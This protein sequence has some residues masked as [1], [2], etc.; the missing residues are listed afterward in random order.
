MPALDGQSSLLY[1]EDATQTAIRDAVS[2]A[3][4]QAGDAGADLIL[5]FL[6]HG[7]T[8]GN[9]P[10][11]YLM[12]SDSDEG[13]PTTLIN[14]GDLVAGVAN[15]PGI[16]SLI[17]V[18]DTCHSGGALPSIESLTAGA[19]EGATRIYVLTSA[20]PHEL[21]YDLQFS[22]ALTEILRAGLP[23]T[24]PYLHLEETKTALTLTKNLRCTYTMYDGDTSQPKPWIARNTR[25]HAPI[26]GS[27]LGEVGSQELAKSLAS[28]SDFTMTPVYG[29]ADL[30]RLREKLI[31]YRQTI[32]GASGSTAASRAIDIT[33]RLTLAQ[34]TLDLF[35]SWPGQAPLTTQRIR[36]T[37]REMGLRH[38]LPARLDGKDL[39]RHCV[40][41]LLIKSPTVQP[42]S[43]MGP[44]TRF[45]AAF[46]ARGG[47][48]ATNPRIIAWATAA[49]CEIEL[50]DAFSKIDIESKAS[51]L[52]LIISL[53]TLLT[54]EWPNT[55]EAWLLS[56]A[57]E[58]DH[59][60]Y[61]CINTQSGTEAAIT[62][63]MK[64]ARRLSKKLHLPLQRIEISASPE[65]LTRWRPEMIVEVQRLGAQ[66][67]IVLRWE[68]LL[69]PA[70]LDLGIADIARKLLETMRDDP[71]NE[72][73]VD[74]LS[75]EDLGR[76]DELNTSFQ[77][78]RFQGALALD[79]HPDNLAQVV[80][81]ALKFVPIV[82]WPCDDA[83]LPAAAKDTL[84]NRWDL[85]P[86]GFSNA[87][88]ESWLT[89]QQVESDV[90]S[91]AK[92]R[93]IW[94]DVEWL[95]FCEYF[96][97]NSTDGAIAE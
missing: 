75:T 22:L 30:I 89:T 26:E 96:D 69:S 8:Q 23:S 24:D 73:P 43:L 57:K 87:Y 31:A 62:D 63:V 70:A 41:V 68:G 77:S 21:A 49:G 91:L 17:L 12:A 5:A 67:D 53:T 51:R 11:L 86:A 1:G 88:R 47:I 54:D 60:S 15:T 94:N 25:H 90:N 14:A 76:P 4:Q 18:V 19:R 44:I 52:R 32:T 9:D 56:D 83:P 35:S 45:I 20:R 39:L 66:Y 84:S 3:A 33:S 55:V 79:H 78:N 71:R 34:R 50:A 65:I 80:G 42:A 38:Q 10:R 46:A 95:D 58:Q 48:D 93:A 82:I 27:F 28:L 13:S 85:L 64:W 16:K 36:E 7:K 29:N 61:Q 2:R 81:Q 40:E 59:V 6:G 97:L 72:A 37:A 92:F 74:W